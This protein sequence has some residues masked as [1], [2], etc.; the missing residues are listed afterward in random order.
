MNKKKN[1]KDKPSLLKYKFEEYGPVYLQR[2]DDM[3][4]T[5]EPTGVAFY[6]LHDYGISDEPSTAYFET[7]E[8]KEFNAVDDN[9][10]VVELTDEEK[11]QLCENMLDELFENQQNLRLKK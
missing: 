1:S 7:V 6:N 11:G 5:C 4:I 3:E 9:G 2:G 8:I 10:E